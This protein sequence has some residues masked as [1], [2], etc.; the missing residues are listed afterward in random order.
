[1]YDTTAPGFAPGM[2]NISVV[3]LSPDQDYYDVYCTTNIDYDIEVIY[4]NCSFTSAEV[5]YYLAM[6]Q[7]YI[8]P[9]IN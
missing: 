5:P 1:M 6:L 8:S 2:D 4:L 3:R 9:Y 7:D